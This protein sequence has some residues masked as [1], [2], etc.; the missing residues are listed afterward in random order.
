MP[1]SPPNCQNSKNATDLL[2]GTIYFLGDLFLRRDL[3]SQL[4]VRKPR[5][6]QGTLGL[7]RKLDFL[8]CFWRLVDQGTLALS[9]VPGSDPDST[10]IL[11][12]ASPE[13]LPQSRALHKKDA[14][15]RPRTLGVSYGCHRCT[16]F[17]WS[18][19]ILGGTPRTRN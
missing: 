7:L 9:Y 8:S 15:G 1:N 5:V 6:F 11:G 12:S 19:C 3:Q 13:D 17:W 10:S 4:E 14:E 2:L 16:V 18:P